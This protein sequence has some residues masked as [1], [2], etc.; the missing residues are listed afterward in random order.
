M[1]KKIVFGNWE[2]ITVIINMICTKIFISFPRFMVEDAGTASWLLTIY[3]SILAFIGFYIISGLYKGFEGKDPI[4]LAE[5]AAGNTGRVAAGIVLTLLMLYFTAYHLRLYAENLKI[6]SLSISPISYVMLFFVT[7]MLVSAKTG[8]ES[9]VRLHSIYVPVIATGYLIILLAVLP[10]FRFENILPV[11][12]TGPYEIFIKGFSRLSIFA[13]LILLFLMAPYLRSNRNLKISGYTAL[14]FS[15]FFLLTGAITYIGVMTY[16]VALERILPIYP[17]SR[18]IDYGRFFQR[19]ESVFVFIWAGA[20]LLY[21]SVAFYFCLEV[22]RKT[23][24]LE[25]SR[26][27]ALPFAAIVSTIALLSP[28][29]M[30]SIQIDSQYF[31]RWSWILSF[32]L[33]IIILMAARIKKSRKATEKNPTRC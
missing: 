27:L 5:L 26:P 1:N 13:E 4:E 16:P 12:G 19:I 28:S 33:T 11:L 7:G 24:R 8:L 6:I 21:I 32:G 9:L 22:F 29:L 2:A 10:L 23:F 3:I 30:A 17:M 25:Y 14:G 18:L 15:C 31:R 20:G